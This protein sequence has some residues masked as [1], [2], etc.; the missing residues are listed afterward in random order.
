[1]IESQPI[2]ETVRR[3]VLVADNEPAFHLII[4]HVLATFD[5]VPLLA[6]DGAA[7][8]AAVEVHRSE[9][10]GAILDIAMPGIDGID[11][12]HVIQRIAP[13]LAMMLMSA[14]YPVDYADRI[15]HLRLAGMLQK[16]FPLAALRELLL[17]TVVEGNVP[18][19]RMERGDA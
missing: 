11:A 4:T 12:A 18:E 13:E 15:G 8:I 1:M 14:A 10:R 3:L 2:H 19:T 17:H 7:A 5:L 9:L 16:P 6:Y